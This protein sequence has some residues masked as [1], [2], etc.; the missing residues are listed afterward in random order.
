MTHGSSERQQ[1]GIILIQS[2]C[3]VTMHSKTVLLN[4]LQNGPSELNKCPGG[5]NVFFLSEQ[6]I[7]YVTLE[8]VHIC[9]AQRLASKVIHMIIYFR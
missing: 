4:T 1:K 5:G 2:Q 6:G 8:G 3:N 7:C 9:F